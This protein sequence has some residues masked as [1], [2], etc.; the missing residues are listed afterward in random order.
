MKAGRE[1]LWNVAA[2]ALC[3]AAAAWTLHVA[4]SGA[5]YRAR[6]GRLEKDLAALEALENGDAATS[7]WRARAEREVARAADAAAAFR[8]PPE[9][10]AYAVE[11]QSEE[12]MGGGWT[13]KECVVRAHGVDYGELAGRLEELSAE[14]GAAWRL[15]SG[16]W[17]PGAEAG[18]GEALLVLEAMEFGEK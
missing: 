11:A 8:A 12:P 3:V 1:T 10:G 15:R 5:E 9:R 16:E 7:A 18:R 17:T 13:R 4:L 14:G 6:R 2:G